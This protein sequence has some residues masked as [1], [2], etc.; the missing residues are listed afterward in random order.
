M[1]REVDLV[2]YLPPFLQEYKETVAALAAENPEFLLIWNAVDRILYNH[3]IETADYNGIA[4]FERLLGI[5]PSSDDTLE[6][7]RSRVRIQWV[8]LL[9]YTMRTLLQKLN[10]LCGNDAYIISHN[11]REGYTLSVITYLE[12]YGQTE[13]LNNLLQ[14]ILPQN[15]VI[16]SQNQLICTARS[17]GHFASRLAIHADIKITHD[18]NETWRIDRD[19]GFVGVVTHTD[20]IQLSQD[21]SETMIPKGNI[22][23]A[24]QIGYCDFIEIK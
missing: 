18:F 4:H 22:K 2:S 1:V 8:N 7:R 9:P 5:Y 10:V 20:R 12:T 6:S 14:E 21:F 19:A 24:S 15:I 13:E 11:F 16:D 23:A 17:N 3:F